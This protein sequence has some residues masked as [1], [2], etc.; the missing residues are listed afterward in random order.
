[1][2]VNTS[3]VVNLM[4]TLAKSFDLGV[5]QVPQGKALSYTWASGTLVNQADRVW[6]DTRTTAGTDSLDL[7]ASLTDA[8]GDSFTLARVKALLVAA[9]GTNVGDVRVTRPTNGV[10]I[11]GA[12]GDYVTVRPGGAFLWVAPDV[13]GVAVTSGTSDLLDIVSSSGSVTFDIAII[14]ASA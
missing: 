11:L 8:F 1:M 14:G 12:T 2:A 13:T 7:N 3:I 5:G 10:Q 4:A 9:S 6:S